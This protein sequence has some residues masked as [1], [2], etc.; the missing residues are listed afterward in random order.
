MKSFFLGAGL[1]ALLA[2][3]AAALPPDVASGNSPTAFVGFSFSFGNG[4]VSSGVS[5]RIFSSDA[6]NEWAA[7]AGVS[8]YFT[9]ETG[10]GIDLGVARNFTNSAG[11]VGYDFL[12]NQPVISFGLTRTQDAAVAAR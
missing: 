7:G 2:A 10:V 6:A 12:R 5:A 3:P 4:T 9:G 11:F 1:A 8:Y